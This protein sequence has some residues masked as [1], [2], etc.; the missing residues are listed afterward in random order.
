MPRTRIKICGVRDIATALTAAATGADAI[1]LVFVPRSPRHVDIDQAQ[2]I[3]RALPAMVEPIGLFANQPPDQ[4]SLTARTVGLRTI[5]L[6]GH[7]QPHQWQGLEDLRLIKAIAFD[8]Q[9]LLAQLALWRGCSNL[10]ALLWDAPSPSDIACSGGLGQPFDWAQLAEFQRD[11]ETEDLPPSI[12]A[13]GLTPANVGQAISSL[14]PFA[15]DVSSGI[16]SSRGVKDMGLIAVFAQAV[17]EADEKRAA[18]NGE[19]GA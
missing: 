19:R 3:V 11:L 18:G 6:H 4:V 14:H 1:G 15:V 8:P 5:Q 7:E 9:T 10:A 17:R 2:Q 16:E 13:G 12:L